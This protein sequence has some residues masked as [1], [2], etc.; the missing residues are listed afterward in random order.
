VPVWF[1]QEIGK[2]SWDGATAAKSPPTHQPET[3]N[4]E[5][6]DTCRLPEPRSRFFW[7]R[8]EGRRLSWNRRAGRRVTHSYRIVVFN[9]EV[10]VIVVVESVVVAV[11]FVG[12]SCGFGSKYNLVV[13]VVACSGDEYQAGTG[14]WP[15][16]YVAK[17]PRP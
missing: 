14:I 16:M 1:T 8:R 2:R 17:L 9:V 15:G 13:A 7:A 11:V 12:H 5:A 10:V 6:C 4:R 3:R